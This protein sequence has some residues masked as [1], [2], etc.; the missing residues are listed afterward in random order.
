[1]KLT[2][3]I[4][5]S[6]K[7]RLVFTNTSHSGLGDKLYVWAWAQIHAE[8]AWPDTASSARQYKRYFSIC[9]CCCFKNVK[10]QT[11]KTN[12]LKTG[13]IFLSFLTIWES[14][15]CSENSSTYCLIRNLI[16]SINATNFN[17]CFHILKQTCTVKSGLKIPF[18]GNSISHF[19]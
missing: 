5:W 10:K 16:T 3:I 11:N 14:C 9:C 18:K 19:D 7:R 2:D 15:I 13:V 1:M 6:Q 8:R 4:F 12:P 17:A